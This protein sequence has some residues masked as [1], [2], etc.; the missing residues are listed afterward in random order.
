MA[1][2]LNARH[3]DWNSR[4]ITTRGRLLR[5]YAD[6]NSCLIYGANTPNTVPYN[7]AATPVLDIVNTNTVVTPAYLTTCLALSSDHLTRLIDMRCRSS[8]LNSPDRP[9]LRR[10][11][12]S[13][14]QAWLETGFPSNPDLPCGV[15]IDTCIKEHRF[16]SEAMTQSSRYRLVSKMKYT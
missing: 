1:G 16:Q 9:D 6:E 3:V 14:F 11:D 13:K 2:Y 5:G 12:W 15:A 10:N 7:P 8:F 4:L